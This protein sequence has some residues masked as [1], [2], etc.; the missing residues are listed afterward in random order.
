MCSVKTR[1]EDIRDM[2]LSSELMSHRWSRSL[3][4]FQ[5]VL[6]AVDCC[7][8]VEGPGF[9]SQLRWKYFLTDQYWGQPSLKKYVPG[10]SLGKKRQREHV[11]ASLPHSAV[12][13]AREGTNTSYLYAVRMP[14]DIYFF[15]FGIFSPSFL[16][17]W[18]LKMGNGDYKISRFFSWW[19][20]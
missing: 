18:L 14:C 6:P 1:N 15:I 5:A 7:G 2:T 4:C 17:I 3:S 20:K 9:I 16:I 13:Y 11:L 8:A 19:C 10:I 12:A